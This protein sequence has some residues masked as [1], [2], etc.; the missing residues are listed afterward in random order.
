MG[1]FGRTPKINQNRGRDHYPRANWS[2][3][4]GGGVRPGQL[5]GATDKGGVSPTGETDIHPDDIAAS[6]LHALGIDHHSEYFTKTN[7]PVSLVPNG[8]VINNLFE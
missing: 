1:E 4:T 3:L 6:I 5:I 2:L 7:R 8:T